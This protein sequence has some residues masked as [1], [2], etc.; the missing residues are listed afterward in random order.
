MHPSPIILHQQI[1]KV[2]IRRYIGAIAIDTIPC[3]ELPWTVLD[4]GHD[5]YISMSI[6]VSG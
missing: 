2:L 4:G 6:L 5:V 3:M 1:Q